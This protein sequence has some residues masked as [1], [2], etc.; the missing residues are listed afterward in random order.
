MGICDSAVAPR[1][2]TNMAAKLKRLEAALLP[3][4]CRGICTNLRTQWY[5]IQALRSIQALG[6]MSSGI[7]LV[8]S[9][10]FDRHLD[11]KCVVRFL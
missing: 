1:V 5:N 10:V 6:T 3:A 8:Q 9:L 4:H 11:R 7:F 2:K